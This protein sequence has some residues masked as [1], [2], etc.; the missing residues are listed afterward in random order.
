MLSIGS[1]LISL[2]GCSTMLAIKRDTATDK[3]TNPW[4]LSRR[5]LSSLALWVVLIISTFL[6]PVACFFVSFITV[7]NNS[8]L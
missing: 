5:L 8:I 7:D 3:I 2:S 4:S 1:S 6:S